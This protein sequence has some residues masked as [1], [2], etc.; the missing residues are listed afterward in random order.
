M[1][2]QISF[3]L[4][5]CSTVLFSQDTLS[6]ELFISLQNEELYFDEAIDVSDYKVEMEELYKN[7]LDINSGNLSALVTCGI[8][9]QVQAGAI[10]QYIKVYGPLIDTDELQ[11]IKSLSK[12]TINELRK[13]IIIQK[14]GTYL[15]NSTTI[16]THHS[17]VLQKQKGYRESNSL[18]NQFLGNKLKSGVKAKCALN[19][20]VSINLQAE[21]DQGEYIFKKHIALPDS[22]NSNEFKNNVD[23]LSGTIKINSNKLI[24]GVIYIGD[25]EINSLHGLI[26]M[27]SFNRIGA[28]VN[29]SM[30][31]TAPMIRN[32]TSYNESNYLRGVAIDRKLKKIRVLVFGS[33]NKKDGNANDSIN[34]ITTTYNTVHNTYYNYI[35]KNKITASILGTSI[36]FGN[37][38]SLYTINTLHGITQTGKFNLASSNI[39]TIESVVSFSLQKQIRNILVLSEYA[40]NNK[41]QHCI[42]TIVLVSVN[43]KINFNIQQLY[44]NKEYYSINGKKMDVNRQIGM[45][46]EYEVAYKTAFK[47]QAIVS[48]KTVSAIEEEPIHQPVVIYKY[49]IENTFRR[50]TTS[51]LVIKTKNFFSE[52]FKSKGLLTGELLSGT[53]HNLSRHM[54]INNDI[55]F[56]NNTF[57]KRE[58]SSLMRNSITLK[59]CNNLKIQTGVIAFHS[60]NY[61][62]GIYLF[63][64]NS[65]GFYALNKYY[66]KGVSYFSSIRYRSKKR[67]IYTLF[68]SHTTVQNKQVLYEESGN[69]IN[70]NA[71]TTVGISLNYSG[72]N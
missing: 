44:K 26:N 33:I 28:S 61:A 68:V 24:K 12:S 43:R 49:A 16:A 13:V 69:Q 41:Q 15:P 30:I 48:S 31:N 37:N 59:L 42:Q 22:L 2:V 9:N 25:Y 63:E 72:L 53:T 40:V 10:Y 66:N 46:V 56:R 18:S 35:R 17:I 55:I 6:H 21:K 52:P 11:C 65:S 70:G 57:E 50:N 36:Q 58:L 27:N 5:L 1:R 64:E 47:M 7:K 29:Y 39:G 54:Q 4:C 62:S 14:N 60:N 23:Y 45:G 20:I 38:N 32:H 19:S 3:L 34:L 8:I 71:K 51:Y 67:I